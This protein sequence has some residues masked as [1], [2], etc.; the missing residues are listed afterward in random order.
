M[1]FR[2]VHVVAFDC[3]GVMFDSSDANRAF[4]NQVLSHIGMPAMTA[5]QSAFAH[6]HTVD[7]S[8]EYL[9]DDPGRLA[10]A[11]QYRQRMSYHGFIRH[12]VIE[13]HLRALL[14]KL[15]PAFKTAIA[16]NRTDTMDRVLEEHKLEGEFDLVVTALDVHHPKP[17]PEQLQ[18]ILDHF[19]ITPDRMIY[20]GDS[21]LDA[22]SAGAANVPFI[23]YRNA[24]L[25]A[26]L[27]IQ[28]LRQI[29]DILGL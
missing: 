16:T 20:I 11:R 18:V 8:L 5:E 28:S 22:R 27:H 26:R 7:E 15:R 4:Y 2:P 29:E 13:P 19:E 23:A 24:S 6:M 14:A 1:N 9:I 10:E 3:D 12:M 21:D 25:P 17:H